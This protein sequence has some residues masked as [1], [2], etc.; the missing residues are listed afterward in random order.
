MAEQPPAKKPTNPSDSAS[1]TDVGWL[2]DLG[3]DFD[4]VYSSSTS[5]TGDVALEAVSE[6]ASPPP[7]P[8]PAA[9]AAA[10]ARPAA[11]PA[12][13][14]AVGP[15]PPLSSPVAAAAVGAAAGGS[16]IEKK[17][18]FREAA[19]RLAR[20]RDW[21]AL[22]ALIRSGLEGAPWAT[23]P[24]ARGNLL[25][26]LA[27]VYRDRLHD[28]VSAEAEFRRLREVAPSHPEALDFLV[29]RYRERGDWRALF[30]L[31]TTAV[32]A[33]WDPRQ[34]L[35]WTRDAAKI[36][37]EHLHSPDLVIE[38]WER[39]FR[40]G[41][42]EDDAARALS[43]AYRDARKWERLADFLKRRAASLEGTAQLVVLRELAEVNLSGLQ[44][45]E[46]AAQVLD[47]ILALRPS[48]PIALLSMAR[49]LA[50][51]KDWEGLSRLGAKRIAGVDDAV[52]LDVRRLVADVLRAAGEL[53]RA[54]A[55]Y[56][57]I[58][59]VSPKEPEAW[60][61][62]EEYLV[63]HGKLEALVDFLS[64]RAEL[65][66]NDGQRAALLE[67][68]ANIAERELNNP[69]L[70]VSL[71]ERRASIPAASADALGTLVTLYDAISDNNGLRSALERQLT[72][73]GN[74]R[75]RI[76]L[77]RRLG[78]HC[79][80]RLDD[81]A[82]AEACW[83]QI[84]SAVPDDREVREELT[85]L[86][87][88]RGD[89][90]AVDR[91]L[92]SQAWRPSDDAN[93]LAIWRASAVNL[94]ENITDSERTIAA[95]RRVLDLAPDDSTALRALIPH[96]RAL[97]RTRELIAALEAELRI[98]TQ[99]D[100]RVESGL[101]IARL[102][103][104]EGDRVAAVA[105]LERVLR[106]A[107]T[108]LPALHALG[109]L[110]ADDP[111]ILRGATDVALAALGTDAP[112]TLRSRPL[113]LVDAK[114]A[115]GRFFALRRLLQAS[116]PEPGLIAQL[117]QAAAEAGC[118]GELGA[119]YTD[120]AA[121][122][123]DRATSAAY[124]RELARLYEEKLRDPV[125]A[126]LTLSAARQ[127]PVTDLAE[128]EPLL[129]LAETTGRFEDALALLEVAAAA[130]GPRE[131]RR[132]AIY[133]RQQ[134]CEHRLGS[135]ERAFYEAVRLVRLDPHDQAAIAEV[136]RLAAAAR[137]WRS[138]DALYAELWDSASSTTERIELARARH[139]LAATELADPVAALDHLLVLYRLDPG[140]PELESQL[141]A[142]AE[143]QSAWRRAL[144]I[145]EARTRAL[146]G[147]VDELRRVAQLHEER[148]Q[149]RARA[150]DLYADALALAPD[151][152]DIGAMLESLADPA[153]RPVL[154][155]ILRSA[156]ARTS[157]PAR[158]LSLCGRVA[159]IYTELGRSDLALDVHQRII[160]L[161]PAQIPSLRVVISHRRDRGFFRELRDALQQLLDA[162]TDSSAAERVALEL[163]IASLSHTK[164]G[165]AETALTTY[166][167][168]LDTDPHNPDALAGVRS[169]TD[170]SIPAALELRRLR[171]ELQR[172][173]GPRRVELQ[174]ACARL[175][176]DE[177]DDTEGALVTLRALVAESGPDGAGFEPLVQL[178]TAKEAWGELTELLESRA[179]VLTGPQARIECL[180]R[181]VALGEEH[182]QA[183]GDARRERLY[184]QLLALR[185][186]DEDLRWRL[187]RLVRDAER[188]SDLAE[189]LG[190]LT[191]QSS[192]L[193]ERSR[194]FFESEYVR[195]LDR[196]L[197]RSADAEALL[198]A[199]SKRSPSDAE[200]ILWLASIKLR[201]GDRAG[202]LA[203]RERHAKL[204]P[205]AVGALVFCHL[206]EACDDQGG[207]PEQVLAYYRAARGLDPD[208]RPAVEGMKALGRRIKNW[209][210][211]AALLPDADEK[212][213]SFEGRAARLRQ[214]GTTGE[215]DP[216]QAVAW[217]ERA[218]AITP[219]DFAAW[220]AIAAAY[221]QLGDHARSL[222]ARR[223]ALSAFE[224]TTAPGPES[225]SA[226]AARIQTL[227]EATRQAG[228]SEAADLLFARAHSLAP[229]L[230]TAA[231]SVAQKRLSEG[232]LPA[233]YALYDRVLAEAGKLSKE[234]R[235]SATFQR[236]TLAARLGRQGQ[237]VADLRDGLR[238]DPLHPGLLHALA[239]VLAETGRPAA[240]VQ[241]YAQA[242]LVAAQ[243]RQRGLLYARLARLWDDRL[244]QPEEAGVCYD[245]AVRAGIEEPDLMMR[246]L[247]YYRRSGQHERAAA[248]IDELLRR[249]TAPADLA[250]LWTERASLALE[251]DEAQAMEAFDMALSYDPTYQ[252]A[253][254]GLLQLLER[255][256]EWAQVI[257]ILEARADSAAPV[258]RAGALRRLAKVAQTH[259]GDLEK[260]QSYLRTVLTLAPE[261]QDYRD[262]L[263]MLPDTPENQSAR[264]EVASALIAQGEPSMPW[265]IEAGQRNATTGKRR[266]SWV[267]LSPLLTVVY[268]D[269]ALKTLVLGL[270]KEFEKA[271][272][273]ALGG[274]DAHRKVLAAPLTPQLLEILEKLDLELLASRRNPESVGSAR[275]TKLDQ[276]TAV[277]KL[278]AAMS[279]RL[280]IEQAQLTRVDELT[281][282]FRLLTDD[283]PH[284][285]VRSDLL[286]TLS[287]GEFQSLFALVLE[288]AR[289]GVRLFT[290]G[291]EEE[292]RRRAEALLVAAGALDGEG[293]GALPGEIRE[294]LGSEG[295]AAL[296]EALAGFSRDPAEAAKQLHLALLGTAWRVALLVSGELRQAARLL[297]RLDETL[298]KMPSA[299]KLEDLS[300]F[301]A[302]TPLLRSIAAFAISPTFLS[303]FDT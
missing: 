17:E 277:G 300:D 5:Q 110:C 140:L 63:A 224:R 116:S 135:S 24:E 90:E 239:D 26:D 176:R 133:Q 291:S 101:E 14:L 86:Y 251:R 147:T 263:S 208:C 254:D 53:E 259:L 184:R 231:L 242:L 91:A 93:L 94:Q 61:G 169:L 92:M 177:L 23:Q 6:P 198:A 180:E 182:A 77:L 27:R 303:F 46:Q 68:A 64:K 191:A 137:L 144:P 153:L 146:S 249:T 204:L 121:Q 237:A 286:L 285:L 48:D 145:V 170:G 9:P 44:E 172:A 75:A 163:E 165:D 37:A 76:E 193:D 117:S 38:A 194:R 253:L 241:H 10:P 187:L 257:D 15:P 99:P 85:A 149:D 33:T 119:V 296:A 195:V 36:A 78:A 266:Y 106:W 232:R 245:L 181:A 130:T 225:V 214:K 188:Y 244:K 139:T 98:A 96:Y 97:G 212:E 281:E 162:A 230:P 25:A 171:I 160:Q 166:A 299:G 154:A 247:G 201:K 152:A 114:D 248:I 74:P 31:R 179:A 186:D 100:Q 89:F 271:E 11:A 178:L 227:A 109:K 95:W 19:Q 158:M 35:E 39:L 136:R 56:D 54:A 62:K 73:T 1:A 289:P 34:R 65:A 203:L 71:Q 168:I 80:H 18:S 261:P 174:L 127:A 293:S 57:L 123:G 240:A 30:D 167:R 84:L 215:S 283:V 211:A 282:P 258:D 210:S 164:L 255:R 103:E 16:V 200:P 142:E 156:A 288:L 7:A 105:A 260:A 129:K 41:D 141:L 66:E 270:R 161:H 280:G 143:R 236:G 298:P 12:A 115:P 20:N 155:T 113:E 150:F 159:E 199:H 196:R 148:C 205:P 262:L 269:Q 3:D 108:C 202:Y 22:A 272:L 128:I 217:L 45:Y 276:K 111:G 69:R 223:S 4:S 238:L 8:P 173:A 290:M 126:F 67:R 221:E 294:L 190:R 82:R 175:Q 59:A 88:K 235:L 274:R 268:S 28:P 42:A 234:E 228:D 157:H 72:L 120:L 52:Q 213:L 229:S 58:L 118:F 189:E 243:P 278:F 47:R 226:H 219:D 250:A 216:R 246:A 138:L 292:Q 284:V 79:A 102:W 40:L 132:A 209:R 55:I 21:P 220:D 122:A 207:T 29:R 267:V 252:P 107:P 273:P 49:V 43:E 124:Q 134:L 125:R 2:N 60:K 50:W 275:S 218:V 233:A 13:A 83:Q 104:A 151:A 32:E 81:G 301:F 297:T 302:S 51:R 183:V 192:G 185:S 279:E 265:L 87:R 287:P 131:L 222:P 70:A 295:C 206:A 264:L 112:P 256:G 197:E